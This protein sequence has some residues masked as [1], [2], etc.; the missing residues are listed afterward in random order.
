[1]EDTPLT[2]RSIANPTPP[3]CLPAPSAQRTGL[4][5]ACSVNVGEGNE[6]VEHFVQKRLFEELRALGLLQPVEKK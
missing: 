6:F 3:T 2:S 5:V 4:V 1:M